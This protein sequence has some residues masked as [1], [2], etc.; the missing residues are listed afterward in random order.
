MLLPFPNAAPATILH[1]GAGDGR[2]L[3]AHLASGADRIILVEPHPGHTHRL[4]ELAAATPQVTLVLAA[5]ADQDGEAELN[6][7]NVPGLASLRSATALRDIYPGVRITHRHIVPTLSPAAL[8][9][10]CGV[11]HAPVRLIL[12]APGAE[13]V[14]LRA[15]QADGTL[16]EISQ[17]ELRCG[18]DAFFDGGEP[19]TGLRKMLEDVGFEPMVSDMSDPDWPTLLFRLHP[20]VLE[21][22][23]LRSRQ[24]QTEAALAEC[25]AT[26]EWRAGRINEL[27]SRQAENTA[28]GI[29]TAAAAQGRIG[30]LEAA[31]KE[32]T[33]KCD[34]RGEKIK[35]LEAR[36]AEGEAA[37]VKAADA[38]AL[39]VTRHDAALNKEQEEYER[40][41]TSQLRHIEDLQAYTRELEYRQR[42]IEEEM[43]RAEGQICI[44]REMLLS[45]SHL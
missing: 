39:L 31:L 4:Q 13:P 29:K 8:A 45:E 44:L 18:V 26:S 22:R 38:A 6:V 5:L 20:A 3:S 35:G 7:F 27:E 15:W 23:E 21:V 14:L 40:S 12:D 9:L 19:M 42:L 30:E 10:A 36:L 2:E 1:I 37:A 11:L 25:S 41:S 24:Q 43:L 34:W 32:L 33:S 28:A 17:L 16:Y